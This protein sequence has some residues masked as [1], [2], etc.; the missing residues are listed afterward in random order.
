MGI[1][2]SDAQSLVGEIPRNIGHHHLI[3]LWRWCVSVLSLVISL[4]PEMSWDFY[5]LIDLSYVLLTIMIHF[6]WLFHDMVNKITVIDVVAVVCVW[7]GVTWRDQSQPSP[8]DRGLL[9]NLQTLGGCP[10]QLVMVVRSTSVPVSVVSVAVSR[11]FISSPHWPDWVNATSQWSGAI[12]PTVCCYWSWKML[13]RENLI[14][15]N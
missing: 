3:L 13:S 8:T 9:G 7:C 2:Q 10:G 4:Q 15:H 11:I 1:D 6:P 14:T 5:R 12:N